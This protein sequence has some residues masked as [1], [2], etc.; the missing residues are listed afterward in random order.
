MN[1]EPVICDGHLP[2][3]WDALEGEEWGLRCIGRGGWG[4][5]EQNSSERGELCRIIYLERFVF[6]S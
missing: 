1:F 3:T 4:S 2:K 6:T 5:V